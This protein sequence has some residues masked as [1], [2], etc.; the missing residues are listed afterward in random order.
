MLFGHHTD[1]TITPDTL[2][3]AKGPFE[4]SRIFKILEISGIYIGN[5]YETRKKSENLDNFVLRQNF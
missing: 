3:E 1:I 5:P 4:D 2:F